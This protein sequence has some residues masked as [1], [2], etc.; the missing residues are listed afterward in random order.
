MPCFDAFLATFERAKI[1]T[2]R[3]KMEKMAHFSSEI[4]I[5]RANL[6][7][8]TVFNGFETVFLKI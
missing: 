7:K 6:K 5:G 4:G 2:N 8:I 1:R 3:E